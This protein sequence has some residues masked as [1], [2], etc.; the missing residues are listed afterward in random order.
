LVAH[1]TLFE[2]K[3]KRKKKTYTRHCLSL[4]DYSFPFSLEIDFV[5]LE[6]LSNKVRTG[7]ELA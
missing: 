4:I 6:T 3:R 1:A 2:K 7:A 5:E